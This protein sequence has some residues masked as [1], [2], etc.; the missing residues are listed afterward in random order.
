[1]G[2]THLAA[3]AQQST[4]DTVMAESMEGDLTQ[5][6]AKAALRR[7]AATLLTLANEG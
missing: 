2:S 6:N 1:M 7:A 4:R 3:I 5:Q